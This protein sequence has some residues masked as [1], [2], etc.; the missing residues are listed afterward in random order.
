MAKVVH[1]VGFDLEKLAYLA[2][3]LRERGGP[4]TF[5][6]ENT[7]GIGACSIV[8]ESDNFDDNDSP[9]TATLVEPS[10]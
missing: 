7:S 9:M 8:F 2:V 3:A 10:K 5:N 1:H 6:K 4:L